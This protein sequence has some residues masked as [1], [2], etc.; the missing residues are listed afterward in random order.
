[1]YKIFHIISHF[2]LGGAERVAINICKSRSKNIEYHLFEVAK[3]HSEFSKNIINELKDHGII[4]HQSLVKNKKLA[5]LFF[6]LYFIYKTIKLKPNIIHTHTEIPDLS[7][8]LYDKIM[9]LFG[10]KN[11]YVRTIHNTQLWNEWKQ[12]GKKIEP[13]YQKKHANVAISESVKKSYKKNYLHTID[14]FVYNGISKSAEK[15]FEN[16]QP[17]KINILFAGR[18]EHQK[19]IKELVTTIIQLKDDNRFHFHIAGKGELASYIQQKL[20]HLNNISYYDGIFDLGSYLSSFDFLF[21]PSNFEGLSI[22]AIESC[23]QKLPAIINNCR[24][25]S[26]IFPENWKLKVNDNNVE[27]YVKIFKEIDNYDIETLKNEAYK[28]A[29]ER[30]TIEIMQKKYETIYLEKLNEK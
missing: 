24:G 12:I 9:N 25:L 23:I 30:F 29:Y 4:Y 8:F 16:I 13:F 3:G 7:I 27:E 15:K 5:L 18:L 11:K 17:D 21:M 1:M 22:L 10:V 28:F 20:S 26:E 6:P 14:Y 2:D 19:G